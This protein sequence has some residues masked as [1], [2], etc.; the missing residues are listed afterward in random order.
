MKK[1]YAFRYYARLASG[2]RGIPTIVFLE[3]EEIWAGTPFKH[4]YTRVPEFDIVYP[5]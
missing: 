5:T 1:L 4:D 3:F 2:Q